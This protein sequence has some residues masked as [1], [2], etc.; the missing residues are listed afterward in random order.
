M[1][2]ML[3]TTEAAQQAGV[4]RATIL[5]WIKTGKLQSVNQYATRGPGCGYK[6]RQS[7]LNRVVH[8]W[9]FEE[10]EAKPVKQKPKLVYAQEAILNKESMRIAAAN[11]RIAIEF[12]QE[13]LAKIEKLL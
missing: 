10:K 8:G 13:E 3:T 7:E 4:S 2:N 1:D 5:Q 6:I 9:T 11:L 12:A